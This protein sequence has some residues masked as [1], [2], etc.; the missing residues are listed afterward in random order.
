MTW[1]EYIN[2]CN[3]ARAYQRPMFEALCQEDKAGF[4]ISKIEYKL[5][6]NDNHINCQLKELKLGEEL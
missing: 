6:C 2:R 3:K 4:K 1:C 5:N